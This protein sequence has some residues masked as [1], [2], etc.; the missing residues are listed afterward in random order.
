MLL[1]N[2]YL[3]IRWKLIIPFLLITL[4]V[5]AV[6]LPL[7]TWLVDRRIEQEARRRL[8]EIATSVTALIENSKERAALSANFV[9]N[10]P[11]VEA[12][13][14][15]Q[16]RILFE[17]ALQPRKEELGLQELTYYTADFAPGAQPLYYGGPITT[18]RFQLSEETTRIRDSLILQA[19]ETAEPVSGLAI[20]PQSSQIIGVAPIKLMETPDKVR[21]VIVAVFFLDDAFIANISNILKVDIAIVKDNAPLVS[22]IDQ[23]SGYELL[24]REGF[25]DPT[26][27]KATQIE[28]A[29]ETQ[30]LLSHPLILDEE[31]Q[32]AVL[33]A[34]S[35]RNFIDVKR[36]IQLV[37]ALFAAVIALASLVFGL[38]IV[39]NFARPLAQL[40]SAAQSVSSG[41]LDQRVPIA[42]FVV[43]D[44]ITDLSENFNIMTERLQSLY[45]GLEQRVQ[46]R[47]HELVEER[48]KL[49]TALHELA[50][51]RDQAEEANR[52]KS[53]FLAAMSHELRTPLNAIIGYSEMLQEE[54]EDLGYEDI[55]PDLKKIHTAGKHLLVLINDILDLSK[56]EA[57]KMNLYLESFDISTLIRETISTI[58]PLVE[59]NANRLIVH[60][61]DSIGLMHADMTKVRQALFNLLSNA[62]KFT[63]EGTITLNVVR[64][65]HNEI[66]WINFEVSDT[67]IGIKPEQLG[68]LFQVF[69]QADASTTRQYGGTGLGLALSRKLCQ[70]MGGDITVASEE[71]KGSTFTIRLPVAV[72][73]RSEPAL[74]AQQP[75]DTGLATVSRTS[76]QPKESTILVID[77]DP[78]ARDLLAR[79]LA[80]EGFHIE[81]ASNGIEGLRRAREIRPDVIALDVLLPGMDGWTVLT[82]LKSDPDLAHIPVI[83]LT[84]V[85]NKDLGFALGAAD[86][87]NKPIDRKRL[88][89]IL[90]K[91]R[92]E[93]DADQSN[94]PGQI[95]VVEDD[96]ATRALLQRML[97][98]EGWTTVEAEHG[99]AALEQLKVQRPDLIL[100][101]LMMPEM[102]GFQF[103]GE[104]RNS[105]EWRTIPVVV[106]TAM[107]LTVED[108]LRL[109]GYV[110]QVLHK[111]LYSREQLLREVRDLVV[112]SLRQNNGRTTEETHG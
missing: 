57:G 77:D 106:V 92:R 24:L 94:A 30:L 11:E 76:P 68:R 108:R 8:S 103:I 98:Q 60:C 12:A 67:G 80:K 90:N 61:P 38:L 102:D 25:G 97:E 16:N 83:M 31:P 45:M 48:N 86:Y 7:T 54:A 79:Y 65:Q 40:A 47:T 96:T 72:V 27:V 58:Q 89:T 13:A 21:G 104:L 56:I 28:T 14:A 17:N 29:D 91:Y 33:V 6:L 19:L 50:V 63:K 101:D 74:P 81:T 100:L 88:V 52:A 66:E 71:G 51:A 2:L 22:T 49:D 99:R 105:A 9:A 43:R 109:N 39:Y 93:R 82:T 95:L 3:S 112:V 84:I 1:K 34:Q 70:M 111:Q 64:E 53:A 36:S 87:L 78:A 46:E 35:I 20:A 41:Q 85:D 37:L 59:K 75:G 26:S 44:E 107:D 110:Q 62:C 15:I 32:G 18:R 73:E 55:I 69:T 10:L 42:H 5:I 4:L 23:S